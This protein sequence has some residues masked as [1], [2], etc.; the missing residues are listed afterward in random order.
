VP[1]DIT[2]VTPV[3]LGLADWRAAAAAASKSAPEPARLIGLAPGESFS[4]RPQGALVVV[5]APGLGVVLTAAASQAATTAH[6]VARLFPEAGRLARRG[7][8]WT[9]AWAPWGAGGAA[10]A[11]IARALANSVGGLAQAADGDR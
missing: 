10:G 8:W 2:M 3:P 4:A 11:A 7:A 5:S 1:R 9:E 6:D